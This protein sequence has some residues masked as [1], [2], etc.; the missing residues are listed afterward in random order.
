MK[1]FELIA[2]EVTKY[3]IAIETQKVKQKESETKR[4]QAKLEAEMLSD[5]SKIEYEKKIAEMEAL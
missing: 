3:N 5:V 1:N 4:I 2:A